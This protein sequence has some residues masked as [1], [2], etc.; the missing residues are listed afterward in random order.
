M[1]YGTLGNTGLQ[2]SKLSLGSWISFSYVLN[3][4]EILELM[5][6]AYSNGINLFD[7]AEVYG[8]GHSESIMGTTLSKLKWPR[9]NF[10][11]CTKVFW[12]G[13][14]PTAM[15][16]TRKHIRDACHQALGRLNID[17]IDIFLCHRPDSKTSIEETVWGMNV[18]IQ[19]GKILY[20]GTSEWASHQIYEAFLLAKQYHLIPPCIEQF[21]YNMFHRD[22][23][24]KE[25]PEWLIKMGIGALTT[26]PLANGILA[27]KY[28]NDTVPIDS[29]ANLQSHFYF[30]RAILSEQ[31]MKKIEQAKKL[32]KI[33]EELDMSLPQMVLAWSLNKVQNGSVIIGV[34]RLTQLEDNLKSINIQLDENVEQR[35]ELILNNKPL[36]HVEPSYEEVLSES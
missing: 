36:L 22:K 3:E 19:Q 20:W 21:E 5:S 26:M 24:E 11:I 8:A 30:K 12:G 18:L 23:G 15:G 14:A 1:E 32:A 28:N 25:Y 31:G 27:G 33:A 7:N 9:E 10:L 29:R 13:S 16:L 34:S 35:I 2:V 6:M 4:K 17:Y